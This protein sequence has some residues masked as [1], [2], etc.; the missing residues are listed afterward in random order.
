MKIGL[1]LVPVPL[2]MLADTARLAEELGFESGWI[3]EHIALP[4]KPRVPYPYGEASFRP[5]TPFLEAFVALG[6]VATVTET[7]RLGTGICILP[8]RQFFTTA[9]A[10]TTVDNISGGRLE[11]GV[12][13]G[14][15]PDEFELCGADFKRRGKV[16]DEYL[17]GLDALWQ[18]EH[19]SFQGESLRFDNLGFQPKPVQKPRVPVFVGG[20]VPA[21]LRRAAKR[22]DG[23]YGAA[24]SP[25]DAHQHVDTLRALLR[26]EGRDPDNFGMTVMVWELPDKKTVDDYARAG[27]DRLICTPFN[28]PRYEAEP[29][30]KLR[31]LPDFAG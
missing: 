31:T 21:A 2:P 29:M 19:P 25:E 30:T 17:D 8:A 22:G 20:F 9:R 28:Y 6:H 23:W 10:I 16:L 24:S 27:V 11:L 3:G 14:W 1:N 4:M 7:L 5:D 26:E 15:S 13:T 18:Q 12:G